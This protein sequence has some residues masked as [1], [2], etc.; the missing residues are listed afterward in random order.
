MLNLYNILHYG[1][2]IVFFTIAI[3]FLVRI[4]RAIQNIGDM[5]DVFVQLIP[6]KSDSGP[7]QS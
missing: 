1:S 7:P 3:V 4:A 5:F 6:G 2:E